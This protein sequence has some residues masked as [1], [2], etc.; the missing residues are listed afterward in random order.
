VIVFL[1]IALSLTPCFDDSRE[2]CGDGSVPCLNSTHPVAVA[3]EKAGRHLANQKKLRGD[4]TW[5]SFQASALLGGEF[6]A[7]AEGLRVKKSE[8][9]PDRPKKLNLGRR[10]YRIRYDHFEPIDFPES[11]GDL[12]TPDTDPTITTYELKRLNRAMDWSMRCRD[13]NERQL[14]RLRYEIE[15]PSKSYVITHQLWAAVT[16]IN[17][18]CID[19]EWGTEVTIELAKG[20]LAELLTDTVTTDLS[21]ERITMLCY[22]GAYHWIPKEQWDILIRDQLESGSWG[23]LD[24]HVHPVTWVKENHTVALAFYALAHHWLH[25]SATEAGSC[26]RGCASGG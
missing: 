15:R 4:E 2:I 1:A 20:V 19:R 16:S 21:A 8:K 3:L 17:F 23:T 6:P 24:L 12:P 13:L 14:A 25:V 7:W 9:G 18:G 5:L 26:R 22:A 10:V 11:P